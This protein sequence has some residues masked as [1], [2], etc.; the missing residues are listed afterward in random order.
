[1][2]V[3][4][5]RDPASRVCSSLAF[6]A[7]SSLE[8]GHWFTGDQRRRMPLSVLSLLLSG[9]G[10]GEGA[11]GRFFDSSRFCIGT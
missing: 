6:L 10:I 7:E 9:L 5:G 11:L 1:M 8:G 3:G 4:R 2:F